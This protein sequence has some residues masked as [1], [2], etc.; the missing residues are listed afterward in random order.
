MNKERR[1][2]LGRAIKLLQDAAEIVEQAMTEEQDYLDAM[3]DSIR[4]SSKGEAAQE[5]IDTLEDGLCEIN[6]RAQTLSE[7][8]GEG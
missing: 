2:L 7:L 6:D 4:E 1:K 3:P 8:I 5:A